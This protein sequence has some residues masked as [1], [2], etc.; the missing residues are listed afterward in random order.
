MSSEDAEDLL[1]DSVIELFDLSDYSSTLPNDAKERYVA[2]LNEVQLKC[3][4]DQTMIQLLQ[5]NLKLPNTNGNRCQQ[6]YDY[7]NDFRHDQRESVRKLDKGLD[8]FDSILT[9]SLTSNK[10]EAEAEPFE[11]QFESAFFPNPNLLIALALRFAA[12][13]GRLE[14]F[15]PLSE[16]DII[17]FET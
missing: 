16:F 17:V 15:K 14:F 8:T 6:H 12:P 13:H 11:F 1:H 7:L 5:L 10:T 4:S 2:K 9:S 3:Y